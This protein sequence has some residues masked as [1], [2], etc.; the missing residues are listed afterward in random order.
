MLLERC[1]FNLRSWAGRHFAPKPATK[2][3]EPTRWCLTYDIPDV[4]MSAAL[5]MHVAKPAATICRAN[6]L[7]LVAVT[8]HGKGELLP[9]DSI[10]V[11]DEYTVN[12]G[13]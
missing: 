9:A 4:R 11:R 5:S 13:C 6:Q 3:G 10:A 1:S 8:Q 2:Q 7:S 12:D